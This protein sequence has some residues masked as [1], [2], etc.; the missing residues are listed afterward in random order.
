MKFGKYVQHM[1]LKKHATFNGDW[2]I[3]G[4]ITG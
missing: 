2:A 3:G 1:I 4:A